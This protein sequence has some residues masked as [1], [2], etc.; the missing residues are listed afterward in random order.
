MKQ[1]PPSPR[2]GQSP[3]PIRDLRALGKAVAS[4]Y[5]RP[6]CL[7]EGSC[8]HLP[9]TSMPWGGA[10]ASTYQKTLQALHYQSPLKTA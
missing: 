6:P 5:Q 4:T 7:R 3:P 1:R 2:E 10:V 9:Q 8:L